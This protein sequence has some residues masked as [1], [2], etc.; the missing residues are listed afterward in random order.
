[1]KRV[2]SGTFQTWVESSVA[3]NSL[4]PIMKTTLGQMITK[5]GSIARDATHRLD[6]MTDKNNSSFHPSIARDG[7]QLI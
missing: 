1:V 7:T 6:G 4:E 2:V 5:L 3:N